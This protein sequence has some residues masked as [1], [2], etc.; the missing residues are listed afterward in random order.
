MGHDYFANTTTFAT[1]HLESRLFFEHH[2]DSFRARE[3]SKSAGISQK[4]SGVRSGKWAI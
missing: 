3:N 2:Q 4:Q 1:P